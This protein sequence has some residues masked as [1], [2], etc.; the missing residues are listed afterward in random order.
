MNLLPVL[1]HLSLIHIAMAMLPG[2][3]T[4]AVGYCSASLS[5]RA[6]FEAALGVTCASL[7]WVSLSLAGAGMLL[8]HAGEFFRLARLAGAAYLTYV[9]IRML[10]QSG[11]PTREDAARPAYRSPFLAGALTTLSNPK[12]AVFWT[13][14]FSVVL[15]PAAPAWFHAAVLGLIG[16]QALLWYGLVAFV[17]SAPFGRSRYARVSSLFGRLVGVAMIFFGLKIAD[18][19]RRE[20][21]V[22]I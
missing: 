21:F 10:R 4:V 2:P 8:M 5:R 1:L 11:R 17:F 18:D 20:I 16:G 13:S 3:N 6:G 15:P 19:V 22:R 7:V 12:S 14:V 9:G